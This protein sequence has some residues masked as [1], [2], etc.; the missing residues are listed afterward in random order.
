M[1]KSEKKLSELARILK[2]NDA[3]I[4][5][6]AVISLREEEPFSGVI[7]LLTA[8]YD[9]SAD[10]S[11]QHTIEDFFNDMKDQSVT[12]EVISEIHN[13]W[14][15]NTISML[16]ASCWQSGLDYSDYLHDI[17]NLFLKGDYYTAIECMTVIEESSKKISREDKNEL[18][19]II[20]INPFSGT[21][22]KLLLTEELVSILRK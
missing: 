16:V 7:A 5:K 6:D 4:I 21:N 15:E 2:N 18:I 8:Y 10:R 22:E 12:E 17:A 11:L 14:K 3:R 19:R 13:P 1:I 9:N 20:E